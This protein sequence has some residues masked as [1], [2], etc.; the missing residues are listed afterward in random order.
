MA[1]N[2]NL[3]IV[4]RAL[5]GLGAAATI[6]NGLALITANY[7]GEARERAIG[8]FGAASSMGFTVGLIIGGAFTSTIGY[9]WIFFLSAIVA[10]F[11]SLMTFIVIPDD[12]ETNRKLQADVRRRNSV[13]LGA[14]ETAVAAETKPS[15]RQ[16][17]YLG[18]FLITL[19]IFFL[20]FFLTEGVFLF[21]FLLLVIMF[22][23]FYQ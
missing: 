4:S 16:F 13:A 15:W 9:Q 10:G 19:A 23:L 14:V 3:F 7:E 6:P 21:L 11:Q 12:R 22:F 20:V 18:A 1:T 2:A 8:V 5:Q 17:D